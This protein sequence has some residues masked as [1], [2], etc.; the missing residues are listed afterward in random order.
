MVAL[1]KRPLN[2]KFI[3]PA[4]KEATD[5]YWRPIKYSLFPPLGLAQLAAYLSPDD[6]VVLTD[7]HVE[8]L[9][10]EDNP[11][12]VVIQVYITNAY[13]AYRIADHYR[14]R[15]AFVCLGGLHVTSMPHEAA[16]HADSIFLGPGEQIFPQFLTDFRAGNPQRLY[17]STS[18]RTLER[19]P[20]PR[21]DL[22]KRHCYLV[23]NSIVVTRGCPQHCDFCYKDAFYQGGKTFYTQRVDEALAEISRLPGRH[24]YFLDDHMLGDR[25]F[26]EGLFDGMK[27]MRRLFQGAATVDSILRGN[28][29][30]RAAEAG[31]R[32]IFV[33]FETLA[34][35]NLKQ[36]NKRQNLGRDYK[37][38]TDRLHS[39]GIMINGSF[40]F[41]MDDDG[42]DVFRRTVDWAVEHGVTTA[43]FH[44]QTPYPGTGLHA[45]MEREG[46]MTTRDWNLYDTRHVVYRP[47]R[48]TAEQLKTGYDW[49]YEEF[50]TWSNIAKASLH[51]G[52]LKHQ[53]KHFFYAS[54]WKKFEA[55]WDFIIRTR[56]LNRTTKILES[57]LS[58]V[59]GKKEDHT[60]VP[61]IPSPQNAELVTISTEQVS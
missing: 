37:A 23:P 56:Q 60:F 12:L 36:C 38:V 9:T 20:S 43:T 24:V 61:P 6:Y 47:A 4:L 35:A 46:R 11:D 44:I 42:P 10:L 1:G 7:E 8:P 50:Y 2:V 33:G 45:R 21:R 54:G 19:A 31:L 15:G 28:L 27:G 41:G 39:L 13:R 17:A 49:A 25:R 48:L 32:S 57:V 59:T 52:T 30:E 55:V 53:A 5:P 58:K 18:G 40:V 3:L 26:A 34:P 51:H 29:I 22:I 16:E 14:K